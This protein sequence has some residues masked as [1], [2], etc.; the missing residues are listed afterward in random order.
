MYMENDFNEL[1]WDRTKRGFYENYFVKLVDVAQKIALWVRYT[2]VSPVKGGANP[3]ATVWAVFFDINN[4]ARNIAVKKSYPIEAL[5]KGNG[6]VVFCLDRCLLSKTGLKG[7][8]NKSNDAISWDLTFDAHSIPL[9]RY[10]NWMYRSPFPR[11]KIVSPAWHAN[12]SGSFSAGNR[13]YNVSNASAHYSHYW[14]TKYAEEWTWAHGNVFEGG[15]TFAFE[16]LA[17]K[18]PLAGLRL[19]PLKIF[20][21]YIDGKWHFTPLLK[22]QFSIKSISD[23]SSWH[24]EAPCKEYRFVGDITARLGEMVALCYNAPDGSHRYCHNS[25]VGDAIIQVYRRD[26]SGKWK[27][28]RKYTAKNSVAFENA[29]RSHDSRILRLV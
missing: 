18:V 22:G 20:T 29:S 17:A 14:G 10:P 13:E 8:I 19:R 2:L 9:K 15:E 24:F 28:W 1:R 3:E 6:D 16:A 25:I 26:F 7:E 4:P 12:V 27:M 23:I 21:F 11:T 5:R